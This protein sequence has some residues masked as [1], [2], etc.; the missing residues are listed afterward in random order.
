MQTLML[1]MEPLL[2]LPLL[3][4]PLLELPLLELPLLELPL[5][6]LL[7][8]EL[9]LLELPREDCTLLGGLRLGLRISLVARWTS[10]PPWRRTS[11]RFEP[12]GSEIDFPSR[13][14][15]GELPDEPLPLELPAELCAERVAQSANATKKFQWRAVVIMK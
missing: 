4:L 8:L 1:L 2:E 7:L 11:F 6:E 3:E 5:L 13:T 15:S 10:A 9:P 14:L 12:R